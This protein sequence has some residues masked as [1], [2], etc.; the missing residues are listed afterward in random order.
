MHILCSFLLNIIIRKFLLT[1]LL[2][3]DYPKAVFSVDIILII[4]V[5]YPMCFMLHL[6]F[7]L[8]IF[9]NHI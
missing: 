7:L 3:K 8:L 6:L 9:I 5:K 2:P 1:Y 4:Y